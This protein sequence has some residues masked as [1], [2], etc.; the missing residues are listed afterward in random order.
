MDHWATS[1]GPDEDPPPPVVKTASNRLTF[2][3][4]EWG[5]NPVPFPHHVTVNQLKTRLNQITKLL[6][7][8]KREKGSVTE[9][10]IE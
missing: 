4:R 2:T 6:F 8:K 10:A 1:N 5:R 3:V 7:V 9:E